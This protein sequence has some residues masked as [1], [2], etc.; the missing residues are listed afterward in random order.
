MKKIIIEIQLRDFDYSKEM[1]EV[2]Y[3][4]ILKPTFHSHIQGISK[5]NNYF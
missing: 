3:N 4:I 5:V 1:F 2:I